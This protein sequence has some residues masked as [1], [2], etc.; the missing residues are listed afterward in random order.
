MV[1]RWCFVHRLS[2]KVQNSSPPNGKNTSMVRT[3]QTDLT[4][5]VGTAFTKKCQ[6]KIKSI[7]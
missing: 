7:V 3:K 1:G 5:A 4:F 6:S 2:Q